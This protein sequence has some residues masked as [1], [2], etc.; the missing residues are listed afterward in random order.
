MR[1]YR[2]NIGVDLTLDEFSD[3]IE[4]N[5][6]LED[7][8]DLIHDLEMDEVM[9]YNPK[10]IKEFEQKLFEEVSDLQKEQNT[11]NDLIRMAR[12]LNRLQKYD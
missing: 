5:Y 10:E 1:I 4:D 7:L 11:N 2:G 8:L 3:I 9:N 6:R 12:T